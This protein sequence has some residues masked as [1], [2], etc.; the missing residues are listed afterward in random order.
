MTTKAHTERIRSEL[1]A[2]GVSSIATRRFTGQYLP[3]V[4]HDD[5]HIHAAVF[6]HHKQME[7]FFGIAEGMLIATD[8]RV[9]YLNH[10]PGFTTMD[11]VTYEV[12]FGVNITKAGI[13]SSVTLFTRIGNYTVS[14]ARSGSVK[15]FA[16]FIEKQRLNL[17]GPA[18]PSA[19]LE[20]KV[21]ADDKTTQFLHQHDTAVLSTIERT[22][23]VT[24]A[25]VFYTF[26][27]G[28][29]YMITKNSTQKS[30]NMMANP[31]VALTM[32]DSDRFQTVQVQGFA[33]VELDAAVRQSIYEKLANPHNRTDHKIPPVTK[34]KEGSFIIFR[35][36]PTQ[37]SFSDF[38]VPA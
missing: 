38:L 30:R 15:K 36:V 26:V 9:I 37:F 28:L 11:E 1:K 17:Q 3:K 20:L 22:G 12:V 25:V 33:E 29:I 18:E 34:L 4:I 31:Q 32:Y 21:A 27:E 19:T 7:A 23:N 16:D 35:I 14:F 5:E 13:F 24:G 8:R 2:S 10:K 6:G